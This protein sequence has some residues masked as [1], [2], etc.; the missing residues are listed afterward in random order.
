MESREELNSRLRRELHD[1]LCEAERITEL[2]KDRDFVVEA[3]KSLSKIKSVTDTQTRKKLN[4]KD[5][6]TVND[7]SNSPHKASLKPKENKIKRSRRTSDTSSNTLKLKKS[8]TS[9][10]EN[11]V[12]MEEIPMYITDSETDGEEMHLPEPNVQLKQSS[13]FN[14]DVNVHCHSDFFTQC[15]LCNHHGDDMVR[16]YVYSH[17]TKTVFISRFTPAQADLIRKDPYGISGR[18][19]ISRFGDKEAIS[20]RCYFCNW[21]ICETVDKWIHH[22]STHTGEYR[23]KCRSCPTVALNPYDNI[24][25]HKH[26]YDPSIVI[27]NNF[28]F[29]ENHLY[30]YMCDMCNF[31]QVHYLSMQNHIKL[32]HQSIVQEITFIRFSLVNFGIHNTNDESSI[33]LEPIFDDCT[34]PTIREIIENQVDSSC[35]E[36]TTMIIKLEPDEQL[37]VDNETVSTRVNQQCHDKI[38][39][40]AES[41]NDVIEMPIS[42]QNVSDRATAPPLA[43]CIPTTAN[44]SLPRPANGFIKLRKNNNLTSS[45]PATVF[46]SISSSVLHEKRRE[47]FHATHVPNVSDIPAVISTTS[48]T[49]SNMISMKPWISLHKRL[50]SIKLTQQFLLSFF[51]CYGFNCGFHSDDAEAMRIHLG[52]HH[53]ICKLRKGNYT[54]LQCCYCNYEGSSIKK[55]LEHIES[56]HQFCAFQCNRCFYRS[57]DCNSVFIHQNY[58]HRENE[59]KNRVLCLSSQCK[60]F[61][62][63]DQD[64]IIIKMNDTVKSLN[65]SICSKRNIF[66]LKVYRSHMESHKYHFVVCHIC[67]E[68][69]ISNSMMEHIKSHNIDLYQCVYCVFGTDK[70]WLVYKHVVDAHPHKMLCYHVRGARCPNPSAPFVRVQSAIIP[71]RLLHF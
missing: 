21:Q 36:Q 35:S 17:P 33:K 61:N 57:R 50:D 45:L 14:I 24:S 48:Y 41:V 16:H 65:C 30:A 25:H 59:A 52:D 32:D 7:T 40:E 1:G 23:Y 71:E 46:N 70:M 66:D 43:R 44:Q 53:N 4:S 63:I 19:V 12:P 18:R 2:V 60:E 51:K 37:S 5:T 47:N 20:F 11:A 62:L 6:E 54:W 42:N 10:A 15:C 26:C 67:G 13:Q 29:D 68:M 64:R 28:S 38:M 39:F 9:E 58:H 31:V 49:Q 27:W 34:V 8:R 56:K 55:L 22:I 69:I 3:R